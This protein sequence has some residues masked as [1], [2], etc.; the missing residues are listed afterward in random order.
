MRLIPLALSLLL[1]ALAAGSELLVELDIRE[2]LLSGDA[3]KIERAHLARIERV[4]RIAGDGP[5]AGLL[6]WRLAESLSERD[7]RRAQGHID[8]AAALLGEIGPDAYVR[9]GALVTEA[10]IHSA[11]RDYASAEAHLALAVDIRASALGWENHLTRSTRAMLASMKIMTN[12]SRAESDLEELLR[13]P[14]ALAPGDPLLDAWIY[15]K[16]GD[17]RIHR[18]DFI[19]ARPAFARSIALYQQVS[20]GHERIKDPLYGHFAASCV[21]GIGADESTETLR[22]WYTDHGRPLPPLLREERPCDRVTP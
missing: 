4:E 11:A 10:Y 13:H 22:A 20:P 16:L 21:T 15:D 18:K 2:A 17:V 12:P 8:R 7:P 9:A 6:R 3:E 5:V 14:S 19:G 1:A